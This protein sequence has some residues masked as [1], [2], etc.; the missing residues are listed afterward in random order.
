VIALLLGALLAASPEAGASAPPVPPAHRPGP[1]SWIALTAE[2]RVRVLEGAWSRALPDR[3]VEISRRFL[4]TP[5]VSSPLGEGSGKDPDPTFRYDAVDCLTFVEETIALSLAQGPDEVEP[6]LRELRYGREPRYEDRNHLME[7]Q[8]LPNN[9]R[10]GFVRDVT[11]SYG[12]EDTRVVTKRLTPATWTSRSSRALDLPLERQVKGEFPLQIIPLDKVLEKA[13][14]IPSGTILVVVREDLPGLVTRVSHLGFVVQRRGRT[15][16]R[17]A[18][19]SVYGRVVDE[20]LESFV[21]RNL[22][23]DKWRVTGVG[24]LEVLA[25]AAQRPSA[26]P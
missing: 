3:L 15:F 17:H 6:L 22:K 9:V 18:A 4:N 16:M 8:W 5:Y 24:L 12:G 11:R 10:K 25:P 13:P 19:M 7:A 23:Y 2:E 14:A 1:D 26:L 21:S 20:D